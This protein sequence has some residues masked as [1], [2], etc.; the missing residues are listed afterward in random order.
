[1]QQLQAGMAIGE[2][3]GEIINNPIT[4]PVIERRAVDSLNQAREIIRHLG[5]G[6]RLGTRRTGLALRCKGDLTSLSWKTVHLG[7]VATLNF[8]MGPEWISRHHVG[9]SGKR[10]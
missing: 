9:V 10:L 4:E 3:A 6:P 1:M 7:Q 5:N 2:Q 8:Q